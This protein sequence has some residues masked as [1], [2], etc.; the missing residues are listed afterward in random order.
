MKSEQQQLEALLSAH[1]FLNNIFS[2]VRDGIILTDPDGLITF[3]NDSAEKIIGITR[4]DLLGTKAVN[5]P[6]KMYTSHKEEIKK[7]NK[8][9]FLASHNHQKSGAQEIFLQRPDG[10][11]TP[12]L[13]NVATADDG[14]MVA[15]LTDISDIEQKQQLVEEYFNLVAHDL[16]TPLSVVLGYSELMK[17]SPGTADPAQAFAE[18]HDAGI[19]MREMLEGI[20]DRMRLENDNYQLNKAPINLLACVQGIASQYSLNDNSPHIHVDIA[21]DLYVTADLKL[22]KRALHNLLGNA[23]KHSPDNSI[24]S[25]SGWATRCAVIIAVSDQGQGIDTEDQPYIFDPFFITSVGREKGGIGLGLHI[26]RKIILAHGGNTF[27]CSEKGAGATFALQVP[28]PDES[29]P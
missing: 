14:Q 13:F 24:I 21:D 18:I 26:T 25:I 15:V 16:R 5:I 4:G 3:V 11:T 10:K 20:T 17:Q 27:V 12:L 23:V 8:P 28:Q 19:S 29:A 7:R 1:Q 2:C 22:F 6:V 9:F